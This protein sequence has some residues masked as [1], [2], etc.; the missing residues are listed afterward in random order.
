[1]PAKR[2]AV[3]EAHIRLR[4]N[5]PGLLTLIAPRHPERG[6]DIAAIAAAAG[7]SVAM[8]SRGELPNRN[9]EI[10]VADTV[11]ELGLIYRVAPAVFIGGS[12]VK[13][14]GQNPIEAAKLGAA[15]LHGPHVWN[16][17]EIY[18]ALDDAHGAEPVA[19]PDRLV[20]H[21]AAW[22]EQ[23][24]RLRTGRRC[25]TY[26]GRDARRRAR[27][28][29]G[30]ARPLSD[31][32]A[33]SSKS[34]PCV[35]RPS[36]GAVQARRPSSSRPWG[37]STERSPRGA[38][39]R[40]GRAPGLPVLC[41]GNFTLGGA[42]KTPAVIMLAKMLA[43][44]G[45]RP[46]CLSRGYGGSEA[47]PKLVDGRSDSAAQVGDEALLLARA[48]P[49]V[50]ARDRVG[51]AELARAQGASV[52]ILDD[53][54]QNPSLAKDFTLAVIDAR[55]GIGNACV[56]PAGPLRAPL[57]AQLARTDALLVV[58]EGNAADDVAARSACADA[59]D[60]SCAPRAGRSRGLRTQRAHTSWLSRALATR[61]SFLQ[62]PARPA[63]LYQDAAPF[64][65][66][67]GTRR[68]TPASSSCA[69]S[70]RDSRCSPRK[71]T[72]RAW[73]AIRAWRRS[74]RSVQTLPV[75]MVVQEAGELRRLIK[76]KLPH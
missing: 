55:R 59:S 11:G 3:L 6:A 39:R 72:A 22:L 67:T 21:L 1:M 68:K 31:A 18:A 33:A 54:L 29:A 13:H 48:A 47:G 62:P 27:S 58:G 73:M 35:N 25:R 50:V 14:G 52:I 17:A 46:F 38:W 66:T 30:V 42:G 41:V 57:D 10:Y 24:R 64:R 45:G 75:T 4:A 7:L 49:T 28:H 8:R 26:R 63:S 16:F 2:A 15:I 61:T 5:F 65:T 20:A 44:G 43:D 60:L 32:T 19:G 70:I 12:L 9:T 53:G 40:Q 34:P 37:S 69:P 36:G 56:F 71:R 23:S 51:G 74:P 76:S